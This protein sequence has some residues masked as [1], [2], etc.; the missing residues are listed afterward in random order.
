MRHLTL[1]LAI[2]LAT[3]T[4]AIADCPPLSLLDRELPVATMGTPYSATLP[5]LGGA[6][7]VTV[8]LTEGLLPPGISMDAT[9]KLQGTP[10]GTGEYPFA[11]LAADSCTPIR[12]QAPRKFRLAV[13][14]PGETVTVSSSRTL[15]PLKVVVTPLPAQVTTAASAPVI[16]IRYRL[17]ATPAETAVLESPGYSFLV[18]GSVAASQAVPLTAVLINGTAEL[19]ETIPLAPAAIRSALGS[20]GKILINRAFSGR[21]TT[22]AAVIEVIVKK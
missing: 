15:T 11:V 12:Q 14:K 2:A 4:V 6:A 7:P 20:T 8:L 19:T 9:G 16:T 13:A 10:R 18:D 22:A 5:L 21:S 1:G 17:T 3:S